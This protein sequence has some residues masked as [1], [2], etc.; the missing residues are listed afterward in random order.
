[1][2]TNRK[3]IKISPAQ[4]GSCAGLETS[5]SINVQ[6]QSDGN[7]KRGGKRRSGPD[8]KSRQGWPRGTSE[9]AHGIVQVPTDQAL[10]WKRWS[11]TLMWYVYKTHGHAQIDH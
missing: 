7:R 9:Y 8:E 4:W 11:T 10:S 2:D 6:A 3:T 5:I 1:M